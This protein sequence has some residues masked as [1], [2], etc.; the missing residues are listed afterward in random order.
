MIVKFSILF[1]SLLVFSCTEQSVKTN[2]LLLPIIGEKKLAGVDGTDTI[3]HTIQ[4]FSF[5]NQFNDTVTEKTIANKGRILMGFIDCIN[6][7]NTY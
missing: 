5:I 4:P 2:K 7:V 3:F 6:L 1:L